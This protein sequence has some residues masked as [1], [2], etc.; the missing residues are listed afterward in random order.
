MNRIHFL[1]TIWSDC[2]LIE[3]CNH[4]ALIDTGTSFYYPMIKSYLKKF[5]IENNLDKYKAKDNPSTSNAS[6][7]SLNINTNNNEVD[8]VTLVDYSSTYEDYLSNLSDY[9]VVLV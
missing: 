3:S 7:K 5:N 2:I 1:N 6:I 9:E 8:E 4:Y